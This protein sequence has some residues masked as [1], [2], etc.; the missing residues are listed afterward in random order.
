MIKTDLL[1]EDFKKSNLEI[2]NIN[3]IIGGRN[4]NDPDGSDTGCTAGD[5]GCC[6]IDAC[7]K[8][9]GDG[10]LMANIKPSNCG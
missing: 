1:L 7:V 4:T 5:V 6:D 2:E 9:D 8:D 3:F 10:S